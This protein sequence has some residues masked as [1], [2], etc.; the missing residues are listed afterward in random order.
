[1]LLPDEIWLADFKTDEIRAN[2]LA[3]KIKIYWPQ[4]K[5]YA[6]A[7]SRIYGRPVTNC[8]L[9]FLSARKTVDVI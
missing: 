9:H 3:E 4:L 1:V 7:L 6:S 8:W 2:G 5:L